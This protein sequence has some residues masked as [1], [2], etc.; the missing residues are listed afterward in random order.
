MEMTQRVV[1]ADGTALAVWEAGDPAGRPI[2]LLHG[3]SQAALCFAAQAAAPALARYRLVMPDLRGHGASD[4]PP[5][6]EAYAEQSRWSGDV[7][8]VI[9]ALGLDRPVLGGWSHGGR[10]VCQYLA[11]HGDAALSGV[12]FIAA[13]LVMN[14]A[15]LKPAARERIT[16]M[17]DPD[18]AVS[19]QATIDFVKM[20]VA[21]PSP[22]EV[23]LRFVAFNMLTPPQV[24]RDM[25]GHPLATEAAFAR[26]TVPTLLV[27]GAD[28][29]VIAAED[30]AWAHEALPGST[31]ALL[32]GVGHAPFA[33]D[34]E[35]FNADLAA[36]MATLG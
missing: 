19:L 9:D 4:K 18:L 17:G 32:P 3:Y 15:T 26:L 21:K 24:R 25:H 2:L 6:H 8:A 29:A 28:D 20:C 5:A 27:H 34:P 7:A 1:S 23:L 33:E 12:V 14:P 10:I 11:D 22:E 30:S 36:F 35:R 16:A 31:L 13:R